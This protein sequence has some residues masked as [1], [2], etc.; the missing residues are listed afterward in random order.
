M[1]LKDKLRQALKERYGLDN[2]E[3]IMKEVGDAMMIE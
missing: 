2:D 3:E 1:E